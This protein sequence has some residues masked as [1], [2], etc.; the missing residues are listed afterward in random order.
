[1]Y[2]VIVAF[3]NGCHF[4]HATVADFDHAPMNTLCSLE[5]T[6]KGSSISFRNFCPILVTSLFA[7]WRAKS[8][9][10]PRLVLLLAGMY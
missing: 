5:V 4:G 7:I 2:T 3:D 1:M 9:D 8:C 10:P 6:G